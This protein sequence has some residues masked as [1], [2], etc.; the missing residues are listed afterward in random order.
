MEYWDKE[1]LWHFEQDFMMFWSLSK[2]KKLEVKDA[3]SARRIPIWNQF[4]CKKN[5]ICTKFLSFW[6]DILIFSSLLWNIFFWW[7][8]ILTLFQNRIMSLSHNIWKIRSNKSV[9]YRLILVKNICFSKNCSV[10]AD[11]LHHL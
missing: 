9:P 8:Y 3:I 2:S 6:K 4:F 1:P 10:I 5:R 7:P 11:I